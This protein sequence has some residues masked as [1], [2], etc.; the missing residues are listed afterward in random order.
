M[1]MMMVIM[2]I[3][4]RRNLEAAEMRGNRK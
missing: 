4:E 1:M 2:M 3:F